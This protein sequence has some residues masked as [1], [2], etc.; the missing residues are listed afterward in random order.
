[1]EKSF[2]FASLTRQGIAYLW[3]SNYQD[4][5]FYKDCARSVAPE[6]SEYRTYGDGQ[7]Q[8]SS[9]WAVPAASIEDALA[10]LAIHLRDNPD[11]IE[12]V[13]Y[14]WHRCAA[15]A[16][17]DVDFFTGLKFNPE[18]TQFYCAAERK[19][20]T[21]AKREFDRRWEKVPEH[22]KGD[23]ESV[24][25]FL[26]ADFW[27]ALSRY[28]LYSHLRRMMGNAWVDDDTETKMIGLAVR[29]N[30]VHQAFR[31]IEMYVT[32]YQ[33]ADNAKVEIA[34]LL[35][36]MGIGEHETAANEQQEAA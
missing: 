15:P 17:A 35:H 27:G 3:D 33:S 9:A 14:T 4:N 26:V 2:R 10:S 34:C 20:T 13:A 21:S 19:K 24:F 30:H 18:K 23:L 7:T 5:G 11:D 6:L 1:M 16:Q 36:N 25:Y 8:H 31:S 32:S 22:A 28:A 29:K 12:A